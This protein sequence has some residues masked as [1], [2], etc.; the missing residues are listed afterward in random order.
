MIPYYQML[1]HI[2]Q[3]IIDEQTSRVKAY[4]EHWLAFMSDCVCFWEIPGDLDIHTQGHCE[5]V[6]LHALRIGEARHA[7]DRQMTALAEASV[8]HDSRRK[9]NYLDTG[10]GARAANYYKDYCG[11]GGLEFLPEAYTAIWYH[12]RDDEL[13]SRYIAT[14]AGTEADSWLEVYRCF[15]DADALDRYRLGTWCLDKRFLRTDVAKTMTDFALMLVQ[16]TIPEDELRRTYSQTD[17][18]RPEDAE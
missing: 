2:P 11:K 1:M 3:S 14:H 10:H 8:F 12:D 13:G 15:K 17:P 9:D 5:R 16:R 7:S 6:L 18:F 4:F